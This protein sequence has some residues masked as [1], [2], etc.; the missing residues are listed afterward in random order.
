MP[1]AVARDRLIE[2]LQRSS[3]YAGH[4]DARAVNNWNGLTTYLLKEATPQAWL[5]AGKRFRRLRGSIPLGDLGGDR[6]VLSRGLKD[7]LIATGRIKPFQRTYAKRQSSYPGAVSH[8]LAQ[9]RVADPPPLQLAP[10]DAH[11][12]V[13]GSDEPEVCAQPKRGQTSHTRRVTIAQRTDGC[14]LSRR[15][16]LATGGSIVRGR[17][18]CERKACEREALGANRRAPL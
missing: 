10:P 18:T 9:L 3:V 17:L 12:G 1:D 11:C 16:V 5:G 4:V 8:R 7:V 6:V 14:T 15:A 2:S 13:Q